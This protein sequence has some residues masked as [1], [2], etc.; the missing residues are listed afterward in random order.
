MR[1]KEIKIE[2]SGEDGGERN[3]SSLVLAG[4]LYL[5]FDRFNFW[6]NKNS[7]LFF[8]VIDEE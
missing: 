5:T 3:T 1:K 7:K 6:L 8:W 4:P 2:L